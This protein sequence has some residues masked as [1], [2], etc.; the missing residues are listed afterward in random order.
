MYTVQANSYSLSREPLSQCLVV[1]L[2]PS[3]DGVI[4]AIQN[5]FFGQ[6]ITVLKVSFLGKSFALP[7]LLPQLKRILLTWNNICA[8]PSALGISAL[9]EAQ[10]VIFTIGLYSF[11]ENSQFSCPQLSM[12]S[13]ENCF[14]PGRS[15]PFRGAFVWMG[16]SQCYE[17][18]LS[19]AGGVF[20]RALAEREWPC[21]QAFSALEIPHHPGLLRCI[22]TDFWSNHSLLSL[23]FWIEG[24]ALLFTTFRASILFLLKLPLHWWGTIKGDLGRLNLHLCSFRALLH[25]LNDVSGRLTAAFALPQ[26]KQ[27]WCETCTHWN[28]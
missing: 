1:A 22:W 18:R 9:C 11:A 20:S 24:K 25:C 13:G 10:S 23:W 28:R 27:G 14:H 8:L 21:S 26:G 2:G 19:G 5:C 3:W 7:L 6:I 16:T 12:E 4:S 15:S 17:M